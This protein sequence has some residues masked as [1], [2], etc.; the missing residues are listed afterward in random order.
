MYRFAPNAQGWVDLL[1]LETYV[2]TRRLNSKSGTWAPTWIKLH[3]EYLCVKKPDGSMQCGSVTQKV[4]DFW[5]SFI[6][7]PSRFTNSGEDQFSPSRCTE[8]F[9]DTCV[10]QCVLRNLNNPNS[11]KPYAVGPMGEDCQEYTS[12]ILRTC[13]RLCGRIF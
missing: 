6:P 8:K 3:H 12:R 2:C 5:A 1:G 7:T 4:A 13:E 11:R 10:D 9:N